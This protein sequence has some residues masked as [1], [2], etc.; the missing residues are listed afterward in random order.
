MCKITHARLLEVLEY[1]PATGVFVWKKA[2]SRRVKPGD[3][4]GC[5]AHRGYRL[6]KVDGVLYLEH[7]LAWFYMHGEWPTVIDHKRSKSNAIENLKNTTQAGNLQNRFVASTQNMSG[8]I[9]AHKSKGARFKS[10][11]KVNGVIVRLG[12][13]G[14]AEEASKAYLEAKKK[15]HQ[16]ATQ[17]V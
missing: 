1:N 9:G 10:Q 14:S 13:F 17:H 7:R 11:I 5:A 15:Y 16:E 12:T 4:A 8:L 6:V 2:L 3:I